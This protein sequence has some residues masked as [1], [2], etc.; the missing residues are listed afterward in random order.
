MGHKLKHN[1]GIKC[2]SP[3]QRNRIIDLCLSAGVPV[4][5][6]TEEK[7]DFG[8]FPNLYFANGQI[9][10][11]SHSTAYNWLTEVEFIAKIFG[12][13]LPSKHPRIYINDHP[14]VFNENGASVGCVAIPF[15]TIEVIYNHCKK[16]RENNK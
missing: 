14:V 10:A 7:R 4:S 1:D 16:L 15:D 6:Y 12:V 9:Q 13:E 11:T 3:E 5:E 2:E 8:G